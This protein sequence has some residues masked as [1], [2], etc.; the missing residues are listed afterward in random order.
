MKKFVP[1]KPK[2]LE[3]KYQPSSGG[4]RTL[5]PTCIGKNDSGWTITGVVKEDY[6]EW[7][8]EFEATHKIHGTVKGDFEGL[9]EYTSEKALNHFLKNHP[10][11]EWD[12]I[13][14][15][16]IRYPQLKRDYQRLNHKE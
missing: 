3:K 2:L 14:H 11:E 10:F 1:K 8:N 7:V 6:Y 5:P 13:T 4:A 16:C 15:Q 9:V 12:V